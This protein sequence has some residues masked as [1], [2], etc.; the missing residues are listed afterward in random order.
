MGKATFTITQNKGFQITFANGWTAS[1]QWGPFNYSDGATSA[2]VAR[3]HGD[4]D[5]DDVDGWRSPDEVARF[6]AETAALPESAHAVRMSCSK[7]LLLV[8]EAH[9]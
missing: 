2:E 7:R 1:V 3:W 9:K 5:V 4:D 6:I 8:A